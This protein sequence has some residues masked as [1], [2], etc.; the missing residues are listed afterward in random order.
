MRKMKGLFLL[1]ALLIGVPSQAQAFDLG[2][3]GALNVTSPR[4]AGSQFGSSVFSS[5]ASFGFG[6]LIDFGGNPLVGFELGALY[7]PR[8]FNTSTSGTSETL[9]MLEFPLM[10]RFYFPFV[11]FGAGAYYARGIGN[12][13]SSTNG[14]ANPDETYSDAGISQDDYGLTGS[15]AL[16]IPVAPAISLV[17][18]AR[19]L[20]AI[21][22]LSALSSTT[23]TDSLMLW[24]FQV[25]AGIKFEL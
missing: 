23:P 13:S 11:S 25:L 7:I 19:V 6:A 15:I 14:V 16:D 18:D 12:V 24:D 21:A 17:A 8:R 4:I 5:A 1:G 20:Y 22:N 9:T 2:V 10:V 3:V